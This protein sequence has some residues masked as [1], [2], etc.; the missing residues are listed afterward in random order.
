[1][2]YTIVI[3][4][5]FLALMYS[6]RFHIEALNLELTVYWQTLYTFCDLQLY[7]AQIPFLICLLSYKIL[8]YKSSTLSS[9]HPEIYCHILHFV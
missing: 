2:Q 8:L 6:K 3:K 5:S 7:S 9:R 4:N 1:M